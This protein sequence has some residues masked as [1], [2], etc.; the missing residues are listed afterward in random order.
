[1]R[2]VGRKFHESVSDSTSA[3][4]PACAQAGHTRVHD[5]VKDGRKRVINFP[6]PWANLVSAARERKAATVSA[7]AGPRS[8]SGLG[9]GGEGG[10]DKSEGDEW[11]TLLGQFGK[12][13]KD[14][15]HADIAHAPETLARRARSVRARVDTGL[16]K[17]AQDEGVG[18]QKRARSGGSKAAATGGDAAPADASGET[19]GGAR[20]TDGKGIGGGGG[21]RTGGGGGG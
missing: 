13:N 19:G 5:G 4:P 17:R 15:A 18:G 9:K 8:A 14:D 2:K 1:M 10:A 11:A 21:L 16:R 7:A 12:G 6:L 20:D 3:D